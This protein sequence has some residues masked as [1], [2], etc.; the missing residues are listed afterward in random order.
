MAMMSSAKP[1]ADDLVTR[2]LG[3]R[4]GEFKIVKYI[5]RGASA[6]VFEAKDANG[7]QVAV[8][9]FDPDFI[10]KFDDDVQI[11][12]IDRQLV[13][14]G[15]HHPN[16]IEIIDGGRCEQTD[17]HYIVMPFLPVPSLDKMLDK[18]PRDSIWPI[19]SQ[20]ALAAKFLEDLEMCHRDIKPANIV[21]TGDNLDKAVLLDLGVIT[22]LG[23]HDLTDTTATKEFV[24]TTRYSPPEF[25]LRDEDDTPEG[26][27]AVTFYQLGAVLHDLVMR[28]PLFHERV[29]P[30][31]KLVRAVFLE[32]PVIDA[33]DVQ[34]E[35]CRLTRL[36][37]LK[38]PE[39]RSKS[40]SWTSFTPR[41]PHLPTVENARG[42]AKELR[43]AISSTPVP[44]ASR[45]VLRR[46]KNA[47]DTLKHQLKQ[48]C[49]DDGENFPPVVVTAHNLAEQSATVK[50]DF[51][52]STRH[53]LHNRLACYLRLDV[54]DPATW[55]FS[56]RAAVAL[57]S[58][59]ISADLK[60]VSFNSIGE[61]VVETELLEVCQKTLYAAVI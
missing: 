9:V 54:L 29:S 55:T 39:R 11:R 3:T 19:I 47:V 51:G 15:R 45:E 32:D 41:S 44:S 33:S 46:L 61:G 56:V 53:G 8:K 27:R 35:L 6:L 34:A 20:V 10:A 17:L 42:R 26:Y 40:L 4:V 12:R 37:L 60:D 28:R 38:D 21:V 59:N 23:L 36:C 30:Y 7:K 24:G 52:V 16:L 49:L 14:K 2:L 13:L 22:P 48:I 31:A 57:H 1:P 50:L 43:R 18:V 5:D 25:L 58:H